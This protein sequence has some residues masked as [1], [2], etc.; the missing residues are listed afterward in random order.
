M[1]RIN[2]REY[3]AD[4]AHRENYVG[5]CAASSQIA[6]IHYELAVRYAILCGHGRRNIIPFLKT[7]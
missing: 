3:F 6:A 1:S 5:D 4:R 7:A 2:D